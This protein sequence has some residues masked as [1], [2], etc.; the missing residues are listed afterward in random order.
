MQIAYGSGLGEKG[1]MGFGMIGSRTT[2]H[3][4][5]FRSITER[6]HDKLPNVNTTNYR[7]IKK[8]L[9][10]RNKSTILS[11]KGQEPVTISFSSTIRHN[12]V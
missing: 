6:E 10:D 1:S 8:N 9:A 11:D 3:R 5:K 7:K 12:P 4:T 2:N